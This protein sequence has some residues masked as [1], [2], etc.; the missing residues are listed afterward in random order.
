MKILTA[1]PGLVAKKCRLIEFINE[2]THINFLRWF[3]IY[4]VWCIWKLFYPF[5]IWVEKIWT[6]SKNTIN[7]RV[8][9][10]LSPNTL[11]LMFNRWLKFKSWNPVLLIGCG[12]KLSFFKH[13]ETNFV[14]KVSKYVTSIQLN[15][16]SSKK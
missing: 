8:K 9:L 6:A 11:L 1:K 12:I 7:R 14:F 16:L 3:R 4:I 13:L 10:P 15:E 2:Q 5:P